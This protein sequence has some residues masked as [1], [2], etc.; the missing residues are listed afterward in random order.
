[1]DQEQ[2]SFKRDCAEIRAACLSIEGNVRGMTPRVSSLPQGVQFQEVNANLMLAVRHM[3]DAR[4]R[5]GK[6]IQW[7]CED[8][9]SCFDK[10]GA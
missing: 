4:M 9:V 7:A 6:A 3:E 2:E 1:M 5:L 10:R 8:G